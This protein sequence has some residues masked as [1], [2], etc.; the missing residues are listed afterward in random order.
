L[1]ISPLLALPLLVGGHGVAFLSE[2]LVQPQIASGA[3]T[4]LHF[5]DAPALY[6][7]FCLI[8]LADKP[9]DKPNLEFMRIIIERWRHLQTPD[10]GP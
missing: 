5:V 3:L 7:E 4:Y 2:T 8:S 10:L 9:V 6:N 1:F